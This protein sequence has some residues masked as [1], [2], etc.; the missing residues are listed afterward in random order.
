M[1]QPRTGV[2]ITA[3]VLL[4]SLLSVSPA[5]GDSQ[6]RIVRL[7]AVQGEVQIDRAAGQGFEKAF[8]N[9][10]ITQG[11][12]I[13][14][15]QDGFAEV[16]FEDASTLRI[17]PGSTI[18]F[19]QLV[20]DDSGTKLS[21]VNVALGTAYL[22]F[23]AAKQNQLTL[24]FD[25]EHVTLA[26]PT[27]LR[28]QVGHT[29]AE[30]AV[31][32]GDAQVGGPSGVFEVQ[33]KQSALFDL[34]SQDQYTVAKNVPEASYD[35]W[36]KHQD[37]F[38]QRDLQKTALNNSP[39]AYGSG[40]LS[41]Y[42]SFTT[43]PGYGMM[44][45]PYFVN[46]GWDPFMDGAWAFYPGMGYGWVSAYPWGWTPYHY[47]SW[48]FVPSYGWMWQPGGSWTGLNNTPTTIHAPAGFVPPRPPATPVRTLVVV[49]RGPVASPAI[50]ASNIAASNKVVIRNGSAGLGIPRGSIQNL[51]KI[52][53]QVEQRGSATATLHSTPAPVMYGGAVN[54]ASGAGTYPTSQGAGQQ[55]TRQSGGAQGQSASS[56]PSFH[57]SASAGPSA[58]PGGNRGSGTHR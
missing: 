49:N 47:G 7:S 30:V 26:K 51:G 48:M 28:L 56:A 58:N 15:G 13:R 25:R 32:S 37:Q 9:L 18:E 4:G 50:A 5:F 43:L 23:A 2:L 27:H 38:H 55:G 1:S 52:S 34:A 40:D 45:Q 17:A 8:L 42:G 16:E 35:S 22:T 44:W 39:Y 46:A 14:T 33:K 29:K 21:T 31:F 11:A 19:P 54:R 12:R 53:Q 36:D 41:Y 20:L 3:A 10:P 24:T 6:V 57:P